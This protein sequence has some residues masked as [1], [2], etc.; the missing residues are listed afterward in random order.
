MMILRPSSLMANI[1]CRTP[2]RWREEASL[3]PTHGCF[4]TSSAVLR[5]LGFTTS[6]LE[7]KSLATAETSSQYGESNS[8]SPL[9]IWRNRACC[10]G[11]GGTGRE[12]WWQIE[13]MCSRDYEHTWL[14]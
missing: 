14:R 8:K 4:N 7:I 13:S 1:C 11:V 3:P 10:W 6:S 12:R 5:C 9:Q 2:F